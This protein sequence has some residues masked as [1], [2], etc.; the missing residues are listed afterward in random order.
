[1]PYE[2]EATTYRLDLPSMY[3]AD[4]PVTNGHAA[5][6][7]TVTLC[8]RSRLLLDALA[9]QIERE[10]DFPCRVII[11]FE[12][13]TMG[14][15]AAETDLVVCEVRTTHDLR[16]IEQR[17]PNATLVLMLPED[18]D[19]ADD[20]SGVI[21]SWPWRVTRFDSVIRFLG[22]L[23]DAAGP[24]AVTDGATISPTSVSPTEQLQ[25]LNRR[26]LDVFRLLAKGDSVK[27][28]ARAL[29]LSFKAIDSQK[30]RIMRKLGLTD[31]VQVTRL[32]IRA[33]LI[34]P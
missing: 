23:R 17:F 25:C 18:L 26:E 3:S 24:V 14:T 20:P 19:P 15:S 22:V 30:Y 34:T 21:A 9:T 6:Q 13:S 11:D 1:M 16:Q 7:R 28:V 32:A 2:T 5:H 27:E 29:G 31:R 10:P 33:G 8:G 12:P 4:T